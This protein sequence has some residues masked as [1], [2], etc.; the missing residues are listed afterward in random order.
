VADRC[1]IE[2]LAFAERL[3]ERSGEIIR[4]Y[5]RQP[6]EIDSKDDDS[7]VTIA[8]REAEE[9][10][11]ALIRETYPDHGIIGE[12]FD[13]ERADAEFCWILDPIDGTGSFIT[14]KPIF[15]TLIA[16]WERGN[17]ILGVIDQ[18]ISGERWVGAAG[19]GTTLN[20]ETA[21]V[22]AC[23]TLSQ[24]ALDST[25]PSMFAGETRFDELRQRVARN[26]WGSD[27]YAYAL[28]ASGHVD[29]VVETGLKL[30]DYATLVPVIE[31]AG[32]IITDWRGHSLRQGAAGHVLA[33]GDARVHAEALAILSS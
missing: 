30:W 29:L 10:L 8:D 2:F 16:L 5:F 12:E 23:A 17:P 28:L 27:C 11:R 4:Q 13:N 7:P 22:R 21:R 14:G 15:G 32:G 24:A 1:P 33:A 6:F 20:G 26:R 19:H 18:P 9:G 25:D 31:Q 3:A